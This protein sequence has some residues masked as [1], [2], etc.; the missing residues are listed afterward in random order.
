MLTL[1][2]I[3]QKCKQNT[4]PG[5]LRDFGDLMDPEVA[6]FAAQHM[7]FAEDMPLHRDE[8]RSALS[9]SPHLPW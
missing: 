4:K 3:F 6:V 9:L 7:S 5:T 2:A 8:S 1:D